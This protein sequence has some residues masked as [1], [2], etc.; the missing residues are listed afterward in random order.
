MPGA[1]ACAV[2]VSTTP[3]TTTSTGS[4]L[5]V[6]VT[7]FLFIWLIA[8]LLIDMD[9]RHQPTEVLGI[10]G[11]VIKIWG[12]EIVGARGNACAVENHVQRLA[13]TQ[14][15]RVGVVIEVVAS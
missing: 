1:A 7:G 13:A 9:F 11:Q 4:S 2:T 8:A 10:V 14:G 15:N 6:E 5:V 12:V 3:K